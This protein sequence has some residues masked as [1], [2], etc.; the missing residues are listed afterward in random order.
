M[1]RGKKEWEGK[2]GGRRDLLT[3]FPGPKGQGQPAVSILRISSRLSYLYTFI[4]LPTLIRAFFSFA[5]EA[6][7]LPLQSSTFLLE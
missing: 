1:M 4:T 6:C 7:L 2:R 3:W 5:L